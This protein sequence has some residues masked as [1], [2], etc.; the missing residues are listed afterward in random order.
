M[1]EEFD[2][3][4]T[5]QRIDSTFIDEN[6]KHLSR[7]DLV[8]K[9]VHTFLRDMP[10]AQVEVLPAGMSSFTDQ[11]NLELSYTLLWERSRR[12]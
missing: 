2:I 9:V 1:Q 5:T 6:I 3:D 12:H 10:D 7:I 8:A 11:E 4:A